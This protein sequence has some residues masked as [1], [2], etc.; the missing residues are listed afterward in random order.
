MGYM[1]L[2]ILQQDPHIVYGDLVVIYPK[3]HS[4]Y[5]RGTIHPEPSPYRLPEGHS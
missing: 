3:L 1:A 4:I 5:L 2:G